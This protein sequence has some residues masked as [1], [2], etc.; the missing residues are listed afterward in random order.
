MGA[1][2]DGCP[3]HKQWREPRPGFGGC[4]EL[5]R[6]CSAIDVTQEELSLRIEDYFKGDS[7]GTCP[8]FEDEDNN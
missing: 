8:L 2:C 5:F 7:S 6:D 1:S 3:Y 4:S